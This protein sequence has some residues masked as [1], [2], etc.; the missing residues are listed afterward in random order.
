MRWI[1][2]PDIEVKLVKGL[3]E[4]SILRMRGLFEDIRAFEEMREL[5]TKHKELQIDMQTH[6]QN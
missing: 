5:D 1:A 6:D 4:L 2:S 3:S